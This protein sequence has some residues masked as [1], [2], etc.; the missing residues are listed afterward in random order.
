MVSHISILLEIFKQIAKK[1]LSK[2]FFL[3]KF[4]YETSLKRN[5]RIYLNYSDAICSEG[6]SERI[7]YFFFLFWTRYFVE[8]NFS[9]RICLKSSNWIFWDNCKVFLRK[10][11]FKENKRFEEFEREKTFRKLFLPNF[12]RH[13]PGRISE[14]RIE[15]PKGLFIIH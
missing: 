15:I 1:K 6:L 11:K 7:E 14:T 9:L 4:F 2:K 8:K 3:C 12:F 5:W 10:K 13:G